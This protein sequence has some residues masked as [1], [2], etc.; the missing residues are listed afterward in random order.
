MRIFVVGAIGVLGRHTLPRLVECGHRVVVVAR[1]PED[2]ARR[3]GLGLS[4]EAH[5]GD[6]LD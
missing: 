4:F 1:R 2:V 6:I 3:L 5:R